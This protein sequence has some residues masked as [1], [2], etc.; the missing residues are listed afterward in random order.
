MCFD[1]SWRFFAGRSPA[2]VWRTA[3]VSSW[4]RPAGFCGER[5]GSR[6]SS[7]LTR[8]WVGIA[9]LFGDGGP[10]RGAVPADPRRRRT[11]ASSYC[12]VPVRTHAGGISGSSA[13]CPHTTRLPLEHRCD[14]PLSRLPASNRKRLRCPSAIRDSNRL[15][16]DAEPKLLTTTRGVSSAHDRDRRQG[17]APA[18][19]TEQPRSPIRRITSRSHA[20]RSWYSSTTS[21]V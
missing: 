12:G 21:R 3:T 9:G 10:T 16:L 1:T 15:A 7:A 18:P 4:L 14:L 11:S 17:S 19:I 2:L 13:S 6:S 5:A 20:F 8:C